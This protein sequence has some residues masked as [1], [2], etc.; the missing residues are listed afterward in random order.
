MAHLRRSGWTIE[1]KC[2]VGRRAIVKALASAWPE[3]RLTKRM[4]DDPAI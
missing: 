1:K 3:P 2:R 4:T